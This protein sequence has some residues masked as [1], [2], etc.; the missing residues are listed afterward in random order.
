M[1]RSSTVEKTSG[2]SKTVKKPRQVTYKSS[3]FF[4]I[5]FCA[6]QD[7]L[8]LTMW[9]WMAANSCSS[10]SVSGVLELRLKAGLPC[11]TWCS[12]FK[13]EPQ[14]SS[15]SPLP[16]E[17][18]PQLCRHLSHNWH[19]NC[20]TEGWMAAK[21]YFPISERKSVPLEQRFSTFLKL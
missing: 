8:K 4:G 12:G 11:V 14:A 10:S 17:L 9:L 20:N 6:A 19:L 7:V 2:D 5:G 18:H 3:F 1:P 13:P 16:I 15:S 21:S